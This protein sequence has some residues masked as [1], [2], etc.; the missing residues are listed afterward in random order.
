MGKIKTLKRYNL[1]NTTITQS[2]SKISKISKSGSKITQSGTKKKN[3]NF[4]KMPRVLRGGADTAS[5][6][7]Y[8][9][10]FLTAVN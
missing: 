10:I 3:L 5:E 2:G 1:R 6:G 9:K 4:K 7:Y 8:K